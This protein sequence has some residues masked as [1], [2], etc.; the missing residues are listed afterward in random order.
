VPGTPTRARAIRRVISA[1]ATTVIVLTTVGCTPTP[2]KSTAPSRSAAA[3]SATTQPAPF[4]ISD[5][6]LEKLP[7]LQTVNVTGK[8]TNRG[9]KTY[10]AVMLTATLY[11]KGVRIDVPAA[12]ISND[13]A[14]DLKPG[15]SQEFS[16][17]FGAPDP[18]RKTDVSKLLAADDASATAEILESLEDVR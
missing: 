12:M 3:S 2:T 8:V 6:K 10:K 5:V 18:S 17:A 16:V 11:A 7:E 13:V 1:V 15:A 9:H 14:N 4:V